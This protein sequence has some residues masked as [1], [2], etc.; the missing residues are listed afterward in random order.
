MSSHR[1]VVLLQIT[2]GYDRRN[3]LEFGIK[4]KN[5][6]VKIRGLKNNKLVV[7]DRDVA[8]RKIVDYRHEK[9]DADVGPDFLSDDKLPSGSSSSSERAP[10]YKRLSPSPQG[11]LIRR[12]SRHRS[13]SRKSLSSRSTRTGERSP[14]DLSHTYIGH[15]SDSG[16][17]TSPQGR[18]RSSLSRSRS[19]S[20]SS[21]SFKPGRYK[22]G[23]SPVL[24]KYSKI[25]SN[26]RNRKPTKSRGGSTTGL[27]L[28]SD[29]DEGSSPGRIGR[30]DHSQTRSSSVGRSRS[31]RGLID[32]EVKGIY[33]KRY[34]KI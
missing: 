25:K 26:K 27:A 34:G 14:Y 7:S 11:R 24:E 10:I 3:N 5:P 30:Q 17:D 9:G 1:G 16:S 8:D 4:S 12:T 23:G 32:E 2:C 28:R 22:I 21:S 15:D 18:V 6:K 13:W 19:T 33:E 31:A 20:S 29:L